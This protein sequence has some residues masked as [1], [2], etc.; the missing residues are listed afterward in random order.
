MGDGDIVG[1]GGDFGGYGLAVLEEVGAGALDHGLGE[2]ADGAAGVGGVVVIDAHGV[3]VGDAFDMFAVVGEVEDKVVLSAAV[4]TQGLHDVGLE[5][6]KSL[7]VEFFLVGEVYENLLGLLGHGLLAL[8]YVLTQVVENRV[9]VLRIDCD[10]GSLL[11]TNQW[12]CHKHHDH[13]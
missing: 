8:L 2:V 10:F 13:C 1:G 4:L 3:V 6:D 5:G 12:E 7:I 11:S 9:P